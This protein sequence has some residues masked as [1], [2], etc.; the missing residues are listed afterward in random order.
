MFP[1]TKAQSTNTFFVC[2]CSCLV[3]VIIYSFFSYMIVMMTTSQFCC[4]D[5]GWWILWWWCDEITHAG[6]RVE[7]KSV[8][9]LQIVMFVV[10]CTDRIDCYSTP[11]FVAQLSSVHRISVA[12]PLYDC[13]NEYE[14]CFSVFLYIHCIIHDDEAD[15]V[16]YDA[17]IMIWMFMH[18]C[19]YIIV[20]NAEEWFIDEFDDEMD[21]DML[22]QD[23]MSHPRTVHNAGRFIASG[24]QCSLNNVL[25]IIAS[26]FTH[27]LQLRVHSTNF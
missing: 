5:D 18:V 13:T 24:M 4:G 10:L 21:D 14:T 3:G 19:R 12:R 9:L 8:A 11:L 27:D 25:G 15:H 20:I 16:F 26:F 7:R 22:L 2:Y 6:A 1:R 23:L 17:C